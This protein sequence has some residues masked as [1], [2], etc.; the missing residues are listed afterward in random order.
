MLK[1]NSRLII[2]L[3]QKIA[4][5]F[6]DG[7]FRKNEKPY[8]THLQDV[9]SRLP[10]ETDTQVVAWLHDILED[11]EVTIDFLIDNE[12]PKELVATIEI[13]TKR[14]NMSWEQYIERVYTCPLASKVK[15]AD[16]IS[17][18]SDNPSSSQI[19][20]YAKALVTLTRARKSA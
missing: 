6:H 9:A 13:L 15:I 20:K 14:S 7:Q 3:A 4:E 18:L 16:L 17:N 12:I 11:T 2:S 19:R 1:M 10:D 5:K 8:I